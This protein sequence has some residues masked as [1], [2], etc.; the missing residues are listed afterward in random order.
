[1]M[2]S[3]ALVVA[4]EAL[5][6]MWK[7]WESLGLNV[8][9]RNTSSI[10][11]CWCIEWLNASGDSEVRLSLSAE[12]SWPKISIVL[13]YESQSAV[14]CRIASSERKENARVFVTLLLYEEMLLQSMLDKLSCIP[15]KSAD[16]LDLVCL[17]L[18][19][20]G[21][22]FLCKVFNLGFSLAWKIKTLLNNF[23]DYKT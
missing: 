14:L 17:I 4:S 11:A 12:T 10:P 8:R 6:S 13:K 3:M 15:W 18:C 22:R 1:M 20:R 7:Q 16:I 23:C 2:A 21:W 19:F 9:A 5:G